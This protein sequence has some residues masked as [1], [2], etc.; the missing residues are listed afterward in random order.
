[1]HGTNHLVE[2]SRM[3]PNLVVAELVQQ[4]AQNRVVWKKRR[5]VTRLPQSDLHARASVLVEAK[6]PC[7]RRVELLE[8]PHRPPSLSHDG[9]CLLSSSVQQLKGGWVIA[10]HLDLAKRWSHSSIGLLTKLPASRL[11]PFASCLLSR[12]R[13]A[14]AARRRWLEEISIKAG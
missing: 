3:R 14:D 10:S 7:R 4:R 1:M 2:S 6:K 13:K 11:S 8:R 5:A 12:S 9:D